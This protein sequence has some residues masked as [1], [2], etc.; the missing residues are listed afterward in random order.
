MQI[1]W[2]P[3]VRVPERELE[4]HY[5]RAGSCIHHIAHTTHPKHIHA[6]TTHIIRVLLGPRVNGPLDFVTA[7]LH[8]AHVSSYGPSPHPKNLV[9]A[10]RHVGD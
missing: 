1:K 6:H 7:A 5:M 10:E 2:I 3:F 8:S 9:E 4:S